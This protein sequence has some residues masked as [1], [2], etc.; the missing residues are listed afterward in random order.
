M[1]PIPCIS[2]RVAAYLEVHGQDRLR[3]SVDDPAHGRRHRRGA[4]KLLSAAG[5]IREWRPDDPLLRQLEILQAPNGCDLLLIPH[6]AMR[7][8]SSFGYDDDLDPKFVEQP[9]ARTIEELLEMIIEIDS[10]SEASV[11]DDELE[12]LGRPDA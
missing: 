6:E 3:L 9:H 11:L 5:A 1:L 7:L 4:M 2:E 10:R 12:G 8:V